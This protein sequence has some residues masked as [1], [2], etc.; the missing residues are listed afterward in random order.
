MVAKRQ[1]TMIDITS[2]RVNFAVLEGQLVSG[3]ID[4]SAFLERASLPG[5]GVSEAAAVADK[6]LA[7]ATNQAA[8]SPDRSKRVFSS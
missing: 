4:R 8:Q 1:K 2:N 6:F 7:I 3:E 5:T